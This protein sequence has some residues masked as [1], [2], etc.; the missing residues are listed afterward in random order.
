MLQASVLFTS[1]TVWYHNENPCSQRASFIS[2]CFLGKIP[3]GMQCQ[4]A[5]TFERLA[6]SLSRDSPQPREVMCYSDTK[7]VLIM[8]NAYTEILGIIVFSWKAVILLSN[9]G[10]FYLKISKHFFLDKIFLCSAIQEDLQMCGTRGTHSSI[11]PNQESRQEKTRLLS[12]LRSPCTL[13]T[14]SGTDSHLLTVRVGLQ[15]I[16]FLSWRKLSADSSHKTSFVEGQTMI[17]VLTNS[18]RIQLDFLFEAFFVLATR[19]LESDFLD[20]RWYP[21][22]LQGKH[23]ALTTG[24]PGNFP[25]EAF[26][27]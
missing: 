9:R 22:P 14:F 17:W 18:S 4:R 15:G 10:P 20:H 19:H 7:N 1:V 12:Y 16:F 5:W 8:E 23:T 25:L 11:S 26:L 13:S 6:K 21:C 24:P 27:D 3:Q 2:A